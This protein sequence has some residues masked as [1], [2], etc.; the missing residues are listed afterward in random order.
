MKPTVTIDRPE[1]I[2]DD[3]QDFRLNRLDRKE[4]YTASRIRLTRN[5]ETE[6]PYL[7]YTQE[8]TRNHKAPNDPFGRRHLIKVFTP[9]NIE[10]AADTALERKFE[11]TI[12]AHKDQ[13]P[14][15][16]PLTDI[17]SQSMNLFL[18][19]DTAT[20]LED[21][22]VQVD[23]LS[24]DFQGIESVGAN[25]FLEDVADDAIRLKRRLSDLQGKYA[26]LKQVIAGE[27]DPPV[28]G[29]TLTDDEFERQLAQETLPDSYVQLY[30]ALKE[31]ID[32]LKSKVGAVS[33]IVFS[34]TA[35]KIRLPKR[36]EGR[37][38]E[39]VQEV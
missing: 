29:Y 2:E 38:H 31:Q 19:E 6:E 5:P 22:G 27:F 13:I 32:D 24:E 4:N 33:K 39:F 26:H 21:V 35:A 30:L 11:D 23:G 16:S 9:S 25:P 37:D 10:A 14:D 20:F 17:H 7:F 28:E 3:I 15:Y 36:L 34:E 8:L 1:R 12:L 18:D